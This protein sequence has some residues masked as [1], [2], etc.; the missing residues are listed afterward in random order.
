MNYIISSHGVKTDSPK[1]TLPK[2]VTLKFYC[3]EDCSLTMTRGY[4]VFGLIYGW[5]ENNL[6]P[7]EVISGNQEV[8]NYELWNGQFRPLA[9]DPLQD[10]NGIFAIDGI[11]QLP[12]IENLSMVKNLK[13]AVDECVTNSKNKSEEDENIIIHCLF[14]RARAC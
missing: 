9:E 4:A 8:D 1:F 11:T 2:N 3:A 12:C 13:D 6:R 5:K 7:V 10:V 14:C